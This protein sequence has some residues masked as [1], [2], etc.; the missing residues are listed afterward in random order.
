[1]LLKGLESEDYKWEKGK[2]SRKVNK[3]YLLGIPTK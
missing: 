1:M 2:I 3:L